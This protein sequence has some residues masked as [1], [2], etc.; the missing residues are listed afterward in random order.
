MPAEAARGPA[1]HHT[2]YLSAV[3][4]ELRRM[5]AEHP[6]GRISIGEIMDGIG[7]RSFGP[8]ILVLGLIGLSPVSN[9][10][11]VVA[12]LAL[13]D[14]LIAGEILVGMDRVWIPG[15][16][17]RRS[18][19]AARCAKLFDSMRR[20]AR[21]VDR[22]VRPRLA[23]FTRGP[24]FYVLALV[25]FLVALVLPVIELIPLAGIIPNA[26]LVAFALAITAHDGLWALIAL[27]FTG[28]SGYLIALAIL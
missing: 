15:A 22:L 28:V 18:M 21:L 14:I 10:P 1:I 2:A 11:G 27:G 16:L 26:A 4:D 3:L 6:K 9:I 24:F 20:P 25:C 8:L 17:S 12:V 23:F 13:L 7:R 5:C 19:A